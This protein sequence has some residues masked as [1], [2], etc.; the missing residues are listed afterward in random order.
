MDVATRSA[1]IPERESVLTPVPE[2]RNGRTS[3]GQYPRREVCEVVQALDA[4]GCKA[5]QGNGISA[6][7]AFLIAGEEC[8]SRTV[9]GDHSLAL[10]P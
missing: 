5:V 8:C 3:G 7:Q 9:V 6:T 4:H 2:R 10:V 1:V